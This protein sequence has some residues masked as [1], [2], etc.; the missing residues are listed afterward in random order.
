MRYLYIFPIVTYPGVVINIILES[1]SPVKITGADDILSL[2]FSEQLYLF[3]VGHDGL[4]VPRVDYVSYSSV[5]LVL[6]PCQVCQCLI[7]RLLLRLGNGASRPRRTL[8]KSIPANY[9]ALPIAVVH[10][11]PDAPTDELTKCL[12]IFAHVAY[13]FRK[14]G[15]TAPAALA[16]P[17]HLL[18]AMELY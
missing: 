18:V 12:Y 2:H 11:R 17:V 7:F 3:V 16:N 1:S 15:K 6:V 14:L 10:A 4:Y 13:I 5:V 8:V 9:P